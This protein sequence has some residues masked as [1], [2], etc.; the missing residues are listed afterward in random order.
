MTVRYEV[1]GTVATIT[2]DRPAQRNAVDPETSRAVAAALQRLDQDRAVRVGILTG[3]GEVFS[4]GADLKAVAAGRLSE[5]LA[6]PGG[7]CGL[8]VLQR[9]KPLV[10][11]VNGHALA[12]GCELALACDVIVASDQADFGLPEVTR[13]IIA[14][15]G[16][17]FRLAL[18][19]P[20]KRAMELLLTGERLSAVDAHALGM[21]NALVPPADVLATA[22]ALGLR[23]AANSPTAVRETRAIVEAAAEGSAPELWQM[24]DAAWERVQAS[25]D[26][27]EGAQAF[28]E[29]RAPE[30][31]D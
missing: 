12:G 6:Q 27:I 13:G 18:T 19:I 3:A 7:F 11:A 25:P 1:E 22:R 10:A 2:L 9:S 15:A 17:V 5:I 16:G 26:A 24:T 31:A 29:R 23:I 21:V 28:A 14:G 4:A 20:P 30:W 8:G